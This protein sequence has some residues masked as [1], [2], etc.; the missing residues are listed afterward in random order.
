M[1][2][3]RFKHKLGATF[4]HALPKKTTLRAII[5][6]KIDSWIFDTVIT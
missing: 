1:C 5:I 4:S 6:Q 2:E 3:D